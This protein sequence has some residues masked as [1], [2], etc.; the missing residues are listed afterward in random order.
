MSNDRNE[1][2][3]RVTRNPADPYFEPVRDKR[4]SE[5]TPSQQDDAKEL[6]LIMQLNTMQPYYQDHLGFLLDRVAQLRAELQRANS[7]M[8]GLTHGGEFADW[9][10][11]PDLVMPWAAAKEYQEAREW[12]EAHIDVG[13]PT[14]MLQ[15]RSTGPLH[16]LRVDEHALSCRRCRAQ[17]AELPTECPGRALT[18]PERQKVAAGLADFREQSWIALPGAGEAPTLSSSTTTTTG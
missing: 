11:G 1:Q 9:M 10:E 7:L 5:L 15:P 6:W 17:G 2:P 4:L 13:P 16:T 12:I 18:E 14:T 3:A 8:A